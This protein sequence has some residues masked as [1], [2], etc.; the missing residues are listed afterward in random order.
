MFGTVICME[1]TLV[2]GGEKEGAGPQGRFQKRPHTRPAGD[3][4]AN[5]M[6]VFTACL[7]PSGEPALPLSPVAGSEKFHWRFLFLS[8]GPVLR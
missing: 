3:L 6:I 2:S 5:C 7:K 1:M 8:L 4:L